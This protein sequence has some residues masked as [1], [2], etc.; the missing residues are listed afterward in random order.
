MA[1]TPTHDQPT[2]TTSSA[3]T[4]DDKGTRVHPDGMNPHIVPE[5]TAAESEQAAEE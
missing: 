2:S 4:T 3:S 5:K 1:D